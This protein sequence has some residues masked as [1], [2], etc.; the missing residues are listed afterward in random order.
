MDDGARNTDGSSPSTRGAPSKK[1]SV[2]TPTLAHPRLRG[3]HQDALPDMN[4]GHGSSPS[5]RGAPAYLEVSNGTI[6]L[7]PVYAG[8]TTFRARAFRC[9]RAHPR[10]RGEHAG[11]PW[12]E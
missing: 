3:E 5:T 2:A 8:S 7:I 11:K 9:S 12:P 4:P 6:R 1:P 10:L